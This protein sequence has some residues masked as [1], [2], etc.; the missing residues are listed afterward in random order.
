M[1]S[2]KTNATSFSNPPPHPYIQIVPLR[3]VCPTLGITGLD[4]GKPMQKEKW[5]PNSIISLFN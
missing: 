5:Q 4:K 2:A 3:G 1:S